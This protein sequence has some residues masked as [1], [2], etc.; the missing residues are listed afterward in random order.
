[1]SRR[2]HWCCGSRRTRGR[3]RKEKATHRQKT[4]TRQ[5]EK[6]THRQNRTPLQHKQRITHT[7]DGKRRAWAQNVR[8]HSTHAVVE[9]AH[10]RRTIRVGAQRPLTGHAPASPSGG[11]AAAGA[12]P[13]PG[14]C[15]M[16]PTYGW[17]MGMP[18]GMYGM[19]VA[20]YKADETPMGTADT[21][22]P[23]HAAHT[24]ANPKITQPT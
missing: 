4:S 12:A 23:D 18:R 8:P 21:T 13:V 11:A 17:Y 16:R 2:G 6:A 14:P 15:G 22:G 3:G 10:S 20:V 24:K 9:N 5:R 1:M 7:Q 19:P